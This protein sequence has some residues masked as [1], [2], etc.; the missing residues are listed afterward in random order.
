MKYSIA[1]KTEVG[2][3][4]WHYNSFREAYTQARS[5][6]R[7]NP[8]LKTII[9]EIHIEGTQIWYFFDEHGMSRINVSRFENLILIRPTKT[10][11]QLLSTKRKGA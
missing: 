7:N 1:I 5:W 6:I 3:I 11:D 2:G 10:L 9:G 4:K 8:T